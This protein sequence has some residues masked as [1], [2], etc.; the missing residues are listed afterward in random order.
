MSGATDAER[1]Q[2]AELQQKYVEVTNRI[3]QMQMQSRSR[4]SDK[5]RAELTIQELG[6]ISDDTK[7]YKAL[8]KAF[9]LEPKAD[10]ITAMETTIKNVDED[11]AKYKT[12]S[13]YMQKTA[14]QTE[15]DLKELL[16]TSEALAR[17]VMGHRGGGGQ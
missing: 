1:Q 14:Q 8:G 15:N 13:E 6:E 3:K 5:R 7:M 11:Q 10:I 16:Q 9:V 17:E 2:F 12:S 4:E